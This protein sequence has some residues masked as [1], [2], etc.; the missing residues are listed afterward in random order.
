M[1]VIENFIEVIR[2]Y[3]VFQGRAS[4]SEFWWYFL[5]LALLNL[6]FII[7]RLVELPQVV[8]PYPAVYIAFHA[9]TACPTLAVT[10]RRLHDAG[11]S[12]WRVLGY[13]PLLVSTLWAVTS[14]K[15]HVVIGL[16]YLVGLLFYITMIIHA[17]LPGTGGATR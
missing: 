15:N 5:V 17:M 11:F 4:R 1:G 2:K 14:D 13:A 7:V 9:L 12:A 3:R 16:F 8:M 6:A 10:I